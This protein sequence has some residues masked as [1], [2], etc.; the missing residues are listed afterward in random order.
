LLTSEAFPV[1]KIGQRAVALIL[2]EVDEAVQIVVDVSSS[3][4]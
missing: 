2:D 1:G 3:I 4:R